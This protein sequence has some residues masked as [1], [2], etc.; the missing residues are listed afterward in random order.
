MGSEFMVWPTR[1]RNHYL[2]SGQD[3][4]M[5]DLASSPHPVIT[6]ACSKVAEMHALVFVVLFCLGLVFLRIF[7]DKSLKNRNSRQIV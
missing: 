4:Y 1:A 3:I 5:Y 2:D 6:Y 7:L